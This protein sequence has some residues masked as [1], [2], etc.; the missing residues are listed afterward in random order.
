[1]FLSM[2]ENQLW[3]TIFTIICSFTFFQEQFYSYCILFDN[4]YVI[5][6]MHKNKNFTSTLCWTSHDI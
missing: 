2:I 6:H 5:Q 3:H 1:M 4:A